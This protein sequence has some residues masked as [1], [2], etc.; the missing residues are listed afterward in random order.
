MFA[1]A[2]MVLPLLVGMLLILLIARFAPLDG[3]IDFVGDA[4]G[5]AAPV[6]LIGGAELLELVEAHVTTERAQELAAHKG[7]G[8][9]RT[10]DR[11]QGQSGA[12]SDEAAQS[13]KP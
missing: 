12:Q 5:R 13:V 1:V 3:Q 11:A 8:P 2:V 9:D 6:K 7:F 4:E 10:Q